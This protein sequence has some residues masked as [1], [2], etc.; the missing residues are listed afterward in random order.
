MNSESGVAMTTPQD[1]FSQSFNSI[2]IDHA[3][4]PEAIERALAFRAP[5]DN[6]GAPGFQLLNDAGGRFVIDRDTGVIALADERLLERERHAA[7]SAKLRVIEPSGA[8]YD[9]E[10]RLRLTGLIPHLVGAEDLLDAPEQAPVRP[11]RI[12]W[13][14]FAAVAGCYT[15]IPLGDENAPFGALLAA[16]LPMVD[17]GFAG[18]MLVETIPAPTPKTAHW[19]L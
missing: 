8:R 4:S 5:P 15:A 2:E 9:L 11:P 12:A 13:P 16:P 19:S 14:R 3:P 7:H 1:P 6:A 18:L 10:I 17:A